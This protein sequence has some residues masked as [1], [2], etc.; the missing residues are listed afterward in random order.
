[1][2]P[3]LEVKLGRYANGQP[4]WLIVCPAGYGLPLIEALDANDR[5]AFP[6]RR[7]YGFGRD[8]AR[9]MDAARFYAD[10][11]VPEKEL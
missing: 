6:G 9:T 11:L 1:M 10:R 4:R 2:N 7:S 5:P 8:L 3:R